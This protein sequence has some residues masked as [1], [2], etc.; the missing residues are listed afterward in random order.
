MRIAV[1]SD[2]RGIELKQAIIGL[3]K[4]LG[5]EYHD[6][7]CYST[8]SVDYPDIAK[9]V[10]V[11]VSAG[12]FEHGILVCGSGIGMSIAANKV[13][14]VR[15]ALC[16]NLLSAERARLHNDANVLCLGQDIVGRD[17]ALGIVSTYL[18]T[19]FEGGRHLRRIEKIG[20]IE[21]DLLD[22]G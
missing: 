21:A 4:E 11:A 2:H 22:K 1:G 13:K 5:H 14:G 20:N 15:A 3:L 10:A 7:G 12:K 16:C 6:F 19:T 17:L 8:D 18:S 9:E